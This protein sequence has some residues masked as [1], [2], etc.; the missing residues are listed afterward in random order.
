MYV[1]MM[2]ILT[3]AAVINTAAIIY[4]TDNLIRKWIIF[5]V[6]VFCAVA[7]VYL[8]LYFKCL[9]YTVTDSDIRK[10]SGIFMHS[11]IS[12]KISS[13]QYYSYVSLPLAR[14]F[15][16]SFIILYVYG[17]KLLLL[18]LD[19]KDAEYIINVYKKENSHV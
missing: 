10:N 18:F 14:R 13:I 19:L 7:A 1:L 3:A 2:L 12:I 11:E 17:G 8:P 6:T 4:V 15:G 5:A 9:H 16:F